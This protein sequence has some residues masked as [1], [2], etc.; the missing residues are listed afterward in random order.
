MTATEATA[1]LHANRDG[2]PCPPWCV[3][4]HSKYLF[5]GAER[6]PVEA[7]GRG[8]RARAI[9]YIP[10]RTEIQV[11]GSG[12]IAVRS[13]DAADLAALIEQLAGATPGQHRELAA[14]IRKAAAEIT[15]ADG[16]Q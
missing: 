1:T 6:I 15:G 10:G 3:T 13:G 4:D 7:P 5:H 9:Q 12:I 8:F 14:A 2:D 11:M 16:A